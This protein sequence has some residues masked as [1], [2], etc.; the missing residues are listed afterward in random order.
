[1]FNE[2]TNLI[3]NNFFLVPFLFNPFA[4][5]IFFQK[6]SRVYVISVPRD[7]ERGGRARTK[8]NRSETSFLRENGLRTDACHVSFFRVKVEE[9][10]VPFFVILVRQLASM[11]DQEM[12]F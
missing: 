2:L 3:A 8:K 10:R 1:M 6:K 11:C 5:F 7:L 12:A 9:F 4:S